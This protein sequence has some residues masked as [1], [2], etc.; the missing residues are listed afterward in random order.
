[1]ILYKELQ[2]EVNKMLIA[3]I[4]LT[5][6]LLICL[7]WGFSNKFGLLVMSSLFLK[8]AKREPTQAEMEIEA[9]WVRKNV[10]KDIRRIFGLER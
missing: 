8:V 4:V 5:L 9:A 7:I 3:L 10:R 1:M 2:E 6:L